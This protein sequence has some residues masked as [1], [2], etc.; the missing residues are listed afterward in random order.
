[1]IVWDFRERTATRLGADGQWPV[2]VPREEWTYL[3]L[4]PVFGHDF[5]VIGDTSKFVTAGDAR[6]EV[7]PAAQGADLIVKG[8]G[9]TV[10]VTGW[11]ATTPT[12]DGTPLDHDAR[13]GVWTL[14]VDVPSRGWAR[15]EVRTAA[16]LTCAG[17]PW[18][19]IHA[20][21]R[22]ESPGQTSSS[23]LVRPLLAHQRLEPASRNGSG[24]SS[25]VSSPVS[26][27]RRLRWRIRPCSR[28]S[29]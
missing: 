29:V 15:V 18:R 9:E 8:A 10:T 24:L 20:R 17:A 25:S 5:T 21:Q 28:S 3:V 22:Q 26:S 13:T 4:A 19:C 27:Q 23:L 14:A 12:V 1:M 7:F 16:G 2:R 11:S 6:L